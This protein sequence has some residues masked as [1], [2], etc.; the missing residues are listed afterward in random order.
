MARVLVVDDEP[1]MRD[2]LEIMLQDEGYEALTAGDARDALARIDEEP[3]DVVITD[4]RMPGVDGLELLRRIRERSPHTQVIVMTAYGTTETAIEA[5]RR[6]AY[7]YITKPFQVDEIRLLVR[8]ALE[9]VQLERRVENLR[10]QLEE[11][12]GF[13]NLVGRSAAMRQIFS[14]VQRVA[15]SK[16]T[17]LITGES[18]TGKEVVARAIHAH[19]ARKDGPFVPVNCGAIPEGLIESELFGH[20]RGAF[21]GAVSSR[22]GLFEAAQGGTLFLDEVGELPPAMQVKL[23]RTLQDRRVKRVG[24]S[25][26][27]PVDVRVIAATNR[28]IEED[29]RAGT[30][31]QDLYYRLNVVR[32]HLPPL[33]ERTEDIPL[34]VQH[35]LQR[36]SQELGKKVR[37]V[38]PAVLDV[39]SHYAFP[40]NVRE[41]ENLVERALT[42]ETGERLSLRSLPRHIFEAVGQAASDVVE[43]SRLELPPEGIDLEATLER[44]ER[45]LLQ[46]ALERTGGNRTEAARLLGIT[47]RSIRYKLRKYGMVPSNAEE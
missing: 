11:R 6:G 2:F 26:E 27:M 28:Q 14:M 15:R 19:S 23:L 5:M 38:E 22:R 10:D 18:G 35:F 20:V 33:R 12:Y 9:R 8:Q 31:R 17:V 43:P 37:S 4:L 1:G 32:I 34:L 40:G 36:F 41:L 47:F 46:Q 29:V 45:D 44:I 42:L 3:F 24:A 7:N 16:A 39:L 30:F 21:T 25:D 13:R